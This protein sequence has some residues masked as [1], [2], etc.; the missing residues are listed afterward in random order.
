MTTPIYPDVSTI[1]SG[2]MLILETKVRV[3]RNNKWYLVK[4]RHMYKDINVSNFIINAMKIFNNEAY[5]I[6]YFIRINN[7]ILKYGYITLDSNQQPET[8]RLKNL[9]PH[10]SK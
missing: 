5:Y 8:D 4:L 2:N 6:K 3:R 1:V 7:E 9:K 10:L